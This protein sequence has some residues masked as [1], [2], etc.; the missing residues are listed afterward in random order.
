ME[1][2]LSSAF[3]PGKSAG[4]M[5]SDTRN[6]ERLMWAIGV[7]RS[8]DTVDDAADTDST[9]VSA[10]LTGL[11]VF[12]QEGRHLVHLGMSLHRGESGDAF[13]FKPRPESFLAP[14]Y[15]E[16]FISKRVAVP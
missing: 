14:R 3:A 10:R 1:R 13:R 9:N 16:E 15:L 11:P 7:F 5:V 6:N 8:T 2:S 12:A 4:L